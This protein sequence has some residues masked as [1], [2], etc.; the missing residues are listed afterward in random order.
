M[1]L[2]FDTL[3]VVALLN[4]TIL[5]IVFAG[6]LW[7]YRSLSATR[8][9]LFSLILPAL[10]T[11]LLAIGMATG[12][13][14][15]ASL[16]SWVFGTAYL[17]AWQGVR[18]FYDKPP[19]WRGAIIILA[20]GAAVM[21]AVVGQG[22]PAQN[23][24]LAA[25][26]IAFIA[27]LML[28][29]LR[30]SLRAGGIVVLGGVALAV[31]GNIAEA[32]A[33][34]SR[35]DASWPAP[36]G[37]LAAWFYLAVIVGGGVSYIGFALMA[38]DRVRTQQRDF[39]AMVTHE[40]RAPLGVIAAVA[41]NLALSAPTETD[42]VRLRAARIQ[43]TVRRMS[44]LIDNIFTG[45]RLDTWQAPFAVEA[46]LD[47]ND[48]LRGLEAENEAVGTVSFVH[49]DAAPVKG[50]RKLLE[51]AL[52]NLIQNALKYSAAGSPVTVRLSTDN[53]VRV[54]VTDCGP[55]IPAEDRE[56]IFLKYYRAAGQRPDGSG[57]G[58]YISRAIARQHGGDLTL[59]ASGPGGSTFCL[60][61]PVA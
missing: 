1:T 24:A 41:D 9:W 25:V 6:V 28:T 48:V 17:L 35:L 8:Y 18:V 45:D 57:L 40:F 60:A 58:L 33:S 11:V 27:P 49:A 19:A 7:A 31:A 30:H 51:I 38:F 47:L 13:D 5:M 12:S 42:D 20:L 23:I 15:T 32:L 44:M 53:H 22:R 4:T 55:G 39:V 10:G 54:T 26:Q 50:D 37:T 16:G 29:I 3:H 43:R 36:D 59:V 34:T 21:G 56:R 52:L 61:L 14:S 46:P 2:D